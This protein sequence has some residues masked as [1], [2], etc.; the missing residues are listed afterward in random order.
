MIS[1]SRFRGIDG[2]RRRAPREVRRQQRAHAGA[3][4]QRTGQAAD[5]QRFR[6]IVTRR[7]R[8]R[9]RRVRSLHRRSSRSTRPTSP[10]TTKSACAQERPHWHSTG[11]GRQ[12]AIWC[13]TSA[14]T[15]L[16]RGSRD[17]RD[18]GMRVEPTDDD[19]TYLTFNSE[20]GDWVGGGLSRRYTP[21]N[22]RIRAFVDLAFGHLQVNVD[23]L[24]RSEWWTLHATAPSGQAILPATHDPVV[25]WS[26]AI[27]TTTT[28]SFSDTGRGCGQL[29]GRFVVRS[30]K[31]GSL[32]QID[33]LHMTFVQQCTGASASLV[34]ELHIVDGGNR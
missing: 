7:K 25:Q 14:W 13:S 23:S 1:A 6:A 22:A 28:L 21:E 11:F 17:N 29:T 32:G 18:N 12:H 33:R 10:G 9:A 2:R 3:A 34:G 26:P 24:D 31:Y 30:L 19:T 5:S 4:L 27:A 8:T 16:L 15:R 20:A